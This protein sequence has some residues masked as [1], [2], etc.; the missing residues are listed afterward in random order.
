MLTTFQPAF[1]VVAGLRQLTELE[2]EDRLAFACEKAPTDD[3]TYQK[4]RR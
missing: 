2:A 4:V 1:H 3:V